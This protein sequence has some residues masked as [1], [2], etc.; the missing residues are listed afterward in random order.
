MTEETLF[1]EV[2]SRPPAERAAFLDQ[3]CAGQSELRAAVEALL[4]AHDAA[5][6]FLT[7]PAAALLD[8]VG[9]PR[10]RGPAARE[11]G[12]PANAR[13]AREVIGSLIG[14]YKLLELLAEGGMGTVY[15]AEQQEPVKRRV[16]LKVIKPGM[17]SSQVLRR[18]E[19]ERQALALMDH[20][21]IAR[22]FDAGTTERGWPYFV[23]ELVKGE[24]I[25]RY[26]DEVHLPIRDR[27]A[28]FTQVCAAI[29]HAHQKGIIHRDIKP[30]NVLV[31][32]Q[33]GRPVPKV[34]DFG[35][36]KA[37]HQKLTERT[38]YTEVGS[39]VGTLEYMSPEQ[40]ELS[41]LD[42]DTRADVYALGV[43]LYELLTGTTPI[44]RKQLRS[45][46]YSEIV[47][48]IKEEEP[49]RPST[50]LS[51][52][53]D[54]LA[55]LATQRQTE[56]GRLTK[57]VRGELDW[58]VMKA[59]EKDRTRR[60]ESASALARDV[61]RYLRD[62][63]VEACPPS[64][65]Y[66]LK[67]FLRRYKGTV[68]AAALVLLALLGGLLGTSYGLFWAEKAR[69][70]AQEAGKRADTEAQNAQNKAADAMEAHRT[71]LEAAEESRQRLVRLCGATGNNYAEAG[72]WWSALLWYN[73]AWEADRGPDEADGHRQRL[74]AVLER[75]PRLVGA[76]FHKHVVLDAQVTSSGER[77]LTRTDE[78]SAYLWEPQRGQ[79]LANLGPEGGVLHAVLA[80]D[81][82]RIATA[83]RD[84]VVRLW[85]AG[86]GKPLV[87]LP[88]SAAV[89][90]TAFSPDSS[91]VASA[92]ADGF[93]RLWQ[94]DSGAALPVKI[95]MGSAARFVVFGPDG[96]R[97]LTVDGKDQ[98]RVWNTATGQALS[99]PLP[100]RM[101][102]GGSGP[103]APVLP[104]FSRDGRW[105]LS[106]HNP[107]P[108]GISQK[109]V[110]RFWQAETGTVSTVTLPFGAN[111]VTF[112][113]DTNQALA[114]GSSRRAFIMQVPDGKAL[115]QFDH[116]REVQ[117][118]CFSLDGKL[119]ATA[120]SGGLVQFWDRQTGRPAG[121]TRGGSVGMN[122]RHV[123]PLTQLTFSAS[124]RS[125]LSAGQDGTAR[126]WQLP[127]MEVPGQPYDFDCGRA[128]L[129]GVWTGNGYRFAL[130]HDGQR[131]VRFGNKEGAA[132][133]RR[134]G[135]EP[136]PVLQQEG[137]V[138]DARFSA[139]GR[140]VLTV[141]A[142][143]IRVWNADT[144][145]A[146]GPAFKV[147]SPLDAPQLSRDGGRLAAVDGT[148]IV[149]LWEVETGRQL[150]EPFR[151]PS[152]PGQPLQTGK[153]VLQ[154]PPPP[155]P[156]RHMGIA[157][158]ENGKYLAAGS[159]PGP[160]P[161]VWVTDVEAGSTV[162]VSLTA[163][164]WIQSLELSP[165]GQHLVVASSDT[166]ARV[167]ESATGRPAGPPLHHPTFARRAAFSPDGRHVVTVDDAANVR[168]WD[169][170]TGGLLVPPL[171]GQAAGGHPH[172]WFSPNG[173]RVLFR[174]QTG[175]AVQWD[176]PLLASS[177]PLSADLMRLLTGR[178][179]DET[180]G[181]AFLGATTFRNDGE[182]FRKAWL[183]WLD[184]K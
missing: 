31:C 166:T 23:M 47:R 113:P 10:P 179:I 30:G 26:C 22:V 141:A 109:A 56:P 95:A 91:T 8:T 128:H 49:P 83:G 174:S 27:L 66:R 137:T 19:A 1:H 130:S 160:S 122:L 73:R 21:N 162:H 157:L 110:V 81:G 18:F 52:S 43:M 165:D 154:R 3:A 38:V 80:G 88:H 35:V 94:A 99:P 57:A 36:A 62:E 37:L 50:R 163:A 90:W 51:E 152:E 46:P 136:G 142:G 167:W 175:K 156:F 60:Y 7:Q 29:Q 106:V 68:A 87:S 84:G 40:A 143:E 65:A 171:L 118:G 149:Y 134:P 159:L 5:S 126:L 104:A 100:H 112:S 129:A 131:E 77:L 115:Q 124:G 78:S 24:L 158:S 145:A 119:I 168:V 114:L 132:I 120:S 64:A 164:S 105:V 48:I 161:G 116:P 25:T 93:V 96:S 111:Q 53:K 63:P 155:T 16:A 17:D 98:A 127:P 76:C 75:C 86:D 32:M 69:E 4:A 14:P 41:A 45:M 42:I 107:A 117:R 125:L 59:L 15:V 61:E 92:C 140:R 147:D 121:T 153:E 85:D 177:T 170:R 72:E 12:A 108:P 184:R 79:L 102:P 71:A 172:V 139:D 11:P 34:I 133:H 58:I 70:A 9:P 176:L 33:D 123:E 2:L 178:E 138:T 173:R 101:H 183:S 103:L 82:K 180:E 150:L 182:R 169:G 6:N 74:A 97:L 151:V 181:I 135:G 148:R 55:S 13:H 89:H 28:L 20:T 144:G 146:I 44:N 39:L 67:K 54:A